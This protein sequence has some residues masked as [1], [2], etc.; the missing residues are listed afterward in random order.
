MAT[1][2]PNCCVECGEQWTFSA[3]T[4][5]L[6]ALDKEN[7]KLYGTCVSICEDC[8]NGIC[9]SVEGGNAL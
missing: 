8:N 6:D 2:I 9:E 4:A 1:Q 5:T 7:L 3:L